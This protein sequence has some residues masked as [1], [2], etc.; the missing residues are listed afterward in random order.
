MKMKLFALSVLVLTAGLKAQDSTLHAV[1]DP[2]AVTNSVTSLV[3]YSG[4]VPKWEVTSNVT[5]ALSRFSGNVTRNL[6]DDPYLLMVRK[7]THNES[8]KQAAWR[9]GVNG[10]R[11]KTEDMTGGFSEVTRSSEE[12]WASLVLGREWRR[13]LGHGFYTFGGFDGRGIYRQ[14]KSV[15]AQFDGW[16]GRT[17]IVTDAKE[18]GGSVGGFGGIGVKL[19]ERISLY[20]ESILY[21]QMLQTE[22]SFSVN[23]A[24]TSLESKQ[25]FSVIPMVPIA[26][27]LTIQF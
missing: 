9:M 10:F 16:G 22:R 13:Q 25:T 20:T 3:G 21:A 27:F 8:G 17:E 14:S 6:N 4:Y 11:R 18:Y 23:G 24:N 7:I 12:N 15:S 19:Q 2:V 1:V 5:L 26:L